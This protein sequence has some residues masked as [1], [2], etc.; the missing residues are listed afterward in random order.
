[1]TDLE[2]EPLRD[3]NVEQLVDFFTAVDAGQ[4]A[5]A[6]REA[7]ERFLSEPN[8]IHVLGMLGGEVVAFGMLRGWEE[9]YRVPSLGIAVRKDHEG[10]GYAR[11]MMAAL[12]RLAGE[13][14]AKQIRLRVHPGNTRARRLYDACGYRD[15]GTERGETLMLLDL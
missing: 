12:A 8:D 7:A 9:G 11:A 2:I 14:G 10:R 1:M 4:F 3:G 13:R 6:T 5:H 15:I